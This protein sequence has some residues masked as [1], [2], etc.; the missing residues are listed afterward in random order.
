MNGIDWNLIEMAGIG[1]CLM[2]RPEMAGNCFIWL[3]LMEMPGMAG[4]AENGW[5]WLK[6]AGSS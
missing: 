3:K 6:I 1:C 5:K 2:S 4:M